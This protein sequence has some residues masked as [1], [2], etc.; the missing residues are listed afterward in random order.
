MVFLQC[1][2]IVV[3]INY[4]FIAFILPLI[5]R[6]LELILMEMQPIKKSENRR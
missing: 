3:V 6:H 1:R 5:F 2:A 4:Q